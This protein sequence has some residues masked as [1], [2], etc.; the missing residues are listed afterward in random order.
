MY[1]RDSI[2]LKK[3]SEVRSNLCKGTGVGGEH[4]LVYNL[5]IRGC[6]GEV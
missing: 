3:T 6:G 1:P 4:I 2:V 5:L